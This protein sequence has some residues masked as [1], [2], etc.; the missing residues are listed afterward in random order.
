MLNHILLLT[1]IISIT[2][3]SQNNDTQAIIAPQGFGINLLNSKGNSSIDNEISN[4]G[5]MNPAAISNFD[6]YSLGLSY[7]LSSKIEE[8]WIADIGTSRKN[9]WMP[10]SA[11][12]V[13]KFDNFSFGLGF[14]QKYNGSLDFDSIQVTTPENPDGTG[15]FFDVEYRTRVYSYSIVASYSFID[16]ITENSS[17][18][19]GFRYSYNKMDFYESLWLIDVSASDVSS[20]FNIGL[21]YSYDISENRKI[22]I[23]FCYETQVEFSSPIIV[24]LDSL[25][26]NSGNGSNIGA[27]LYNFNIAGYIPNDFKLD[28]SAD[29]TDN[30]KLNTLI[31]GMLWETDDNNQKN[32]LELSASGIYRIN[33]MFAPSFGFYYTDKNFDEDF[34]DIN[35]KMNA[36]FLIGGL[37]FNYDIFSVDLVIADAQLFG[38][39]FRKQTIGKIAIGV[40]L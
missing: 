27:Q 1:T 11:G 24:E 18:D 35:D 10:Q 7:Q 9:D 13:F 4:I 33:E 12:A 38:G 25:D 20:N 6:N 3:F 23:G 40:E 14:G 34:F 36:L 22:K 21:Q 31:T 5:F 26:I 39:D 30:F 32:Q 2:V 28:V 8:G 16:L 29:L 15:E 19:L 37:R 17:L